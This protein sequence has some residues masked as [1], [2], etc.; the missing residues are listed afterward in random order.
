MLIETTSNGLEYTW[1]LTGSQGA[2][3][4]LFPAAKHSKADVEAAKRELR[5]TRDVVSIRVANDDDLDQRYK[6]AYFADPRTR[7]L[8]WYEIQQDE[9]L[10]RKCRK[11]GLPP[12]EFVTIHVLPFIESVK[13][14]N[15]TRF[16]ERIFNF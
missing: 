13:A 12:A 9:K 5:D 14:Q 16:G 1:E 2:A 6:S 3:F 8:R 10:I 15:L 11:E 4:T 7:P